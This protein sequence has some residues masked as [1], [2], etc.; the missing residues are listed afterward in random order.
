MHLEHFYILF[1]GR[2]KIKPLIMNYKLLGYLVGY[3]RDIKNGS[4]S[5]LGSIVYFLGA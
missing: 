1:I 2:A 3:G 4:Q 5:D